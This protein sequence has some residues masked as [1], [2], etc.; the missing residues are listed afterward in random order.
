VATDAQFR[1][2]TERAD[3]ASDAVDVHPSP[4]D[5]GIDDLSVLSNARKLWRHDAILPLEKLFEACERF[6]DVEWPTKDKGD[7]RK[8]E[9]MSM[10]VTG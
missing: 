3:S 5:I 4:M 6:G 1:D 7:N 10:R 8:P 9:S 2:V